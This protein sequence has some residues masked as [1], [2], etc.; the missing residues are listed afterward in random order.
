VFNNKLYFEATDGIHGYD[1]WEFD[2][3]NVAM[4]DDINP[5]GGDSSPSSLTLFN[6]KLHFIAEDGSHGFQLWEYD[7]SNLPT[8]VSNITPGNDF[9]DMCCLTVFKNKLYFR[10]LDLTYSGELWV[11]DG[12]N[13]P[14]R[15]TDIN[16]NG[17]SWPQY[18]VVFNEKLYFKATTDGGSSGS[19]L[20]EY[21]GLSDATM[22]A[23]M[24]KDPCC[25]TVFNDKLYFNGDDGFT[26]REVWEYDGSSPPA[27]V[28]D[29]LAGP[30][31]SYPS[32][33]YVFNNKLY[34][35]AEGATGYELYA[36]DGF[37]EPTLVAEINLN[38]NS[39]PR[40]P[41]NYNNKM[42]F[43]ARTINSFY[44]Q[45]WALQDHAVPIHDGSVEVNNNMPPEIFSL[46][47]YSTCGGA[48]TLRMVDVQKYS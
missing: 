4:V 40:F 46:P 31:P 44:Y 11:Y 9:G 22:V 41:T 6:N 39:N 32:E 12:S 35:T 14:T 48:E 8:N 45:L 42:F 29:I 10:A 15:V 37:T 18:L 1:L 23:S 20:W 38:G 17:N 5:G 16:P 13:H 33:F 26:G 2:G 30:Q 47:S 24:G 21:D 27:R 25:P 19:G 28:S 43:T 36:Y 7:G 34:F 3:T